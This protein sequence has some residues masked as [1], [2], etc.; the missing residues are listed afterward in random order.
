MLLLQLPEEVL[1]AD[2]VVVEDPPRRAQ[3]L[4]NQRI[5][6]G[7]SD[8]DAFLATRHDVVGS[9][10]GQLLRHDWLLDTQRVLQFQVTKTDTGG[11][12]SNTPWLDWQLDT[13]GNV[14]SITWDL[15]G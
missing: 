14:V 7:V 6:H 15:I 4:R 11:R 1:S 12:V 10:H 9:Q 5:T 13:Q 3:E 8:V 2:E